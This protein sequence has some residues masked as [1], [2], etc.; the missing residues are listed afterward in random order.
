MPL[1]SIQ[2]A[3]LA[4]TWA[5]SASAARSAAVLIKSSSLAPCAGLVLRKVVQ[6]AS[7]NRAAA[8]PTILKL[9]DLYP[10]YGLRDENVWTRERFPRPASP[11]GPS[12]AEPI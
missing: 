9:T 3:R 8:S 7:S 2:A 11:I 12:G 10:G 4:G 1:A 6:P 5:A